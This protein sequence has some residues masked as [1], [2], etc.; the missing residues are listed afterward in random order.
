MDDKD[1]DLGWEEVGL[2]QGSLTG[3]M[4]GSV[5]SSD[6]Q[7]ALP[8]DAVT[9]AMVSHFAREITQGGLSIWPQFMNT[10]RRYF[11]VTHGYV[12]RKMVWQLLPMPVPKKKHGELGGSQD[13][14]ARVYEGLEVNVEEPDLYIPTM[15]FVTYV[16]LCGIVRG[17]QEQFQPDVLSA[18][19]TFALCMLALELVAFKAVLML[20]GASPPTIDLAA[21]LAY[22][23]FY[24]SLQIIFGLVL[25]W[26]WKPTGFFY[27]LISV[28]LTASCGAA[29]W[30]TLR[31]VPRLQP[32]H[33]Q[34]CAP[35]LY[36]TVIRG[37]PILQAA[38]CYLLMPTWPPRRQVVAAVAAVA[39]PAVQ[40]AAAAAATAAPQVAS[41]AAKVAANS[42]AVAAG[43]VGA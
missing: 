4:G 20:S 21:V 34:E 23:Y 19:V 39:A 12:L 26:G 38:V 37:L 2:Q 6:L 29:L 28:A 3:Q 32:A 10:A 27:Y 5:G 36:G 24:L 22:K 1:R 42:T 35:D 30:Q 14:S 33:G 40:A 41:V 17:I 15:S 25:G 43:A 16:L 11:A 13:W 31:R 7:A 8:V 9:G 18:T